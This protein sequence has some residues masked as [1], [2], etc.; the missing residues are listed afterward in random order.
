MG[1]LRI[2][3]GHDAVAQ[4]SG[5][6]SQYAA[7]RGEVKRGGIA[8]ARGQGHPRQFSSWNTSAV[9]DAAMVG[10]AT[11][12]EK[13]RAGSSLTLLFSLPTRVFY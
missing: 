12:R 10:A 9:E 2:P 13:G 1:K 5:A 8:A 6:G 11:L 7:G 3:A 4:P